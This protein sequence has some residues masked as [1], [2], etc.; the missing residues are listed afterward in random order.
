MTDDSPAFL[1]LTGLTK[2]Y[3]EATA[4]A[5]LDVAVK[6]GELVAFL[7]PSGCGKTTTL[8]MIAGFISLDEG[9]ISIGGKRVDRLPSR[10][11]GTAMVFQD[12]AL[13]PH[14]TVHDNVAF[15]LKMHGVNRAERNRRVEQVLELVQLE[16]VG[17]KY[18]KELSGGMKQRVALAR[19]IVVEP[20]ILLLDEPLSNLDAKLRKQLRTGLRELHD[21]I[22]ITTVFVTHDI[23]EA[24]YLADRVVV[25]SRGHLEQF[26]TPQNIYSNPASVFV[27]DFI[28][29]A[30]MFEGEVAP[31]SGGGSEFR[32]R[33]LTLPMEGAAETTT[34][35]RYTVPPHRIKLSTSRPDSVIA[36]P[37]I[38]AVSAYLGASYSLLVDTDG[39]DPLRFQCDLVA[40]DA[41]AAAL[42]EGTTVWMSWDPKDG[43]HVTE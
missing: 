5:D 30:N 1:K 25:M 14:M 33:G 21:R 17:K 35:G 8:R 4:V 2:R 12:Y 31:T 10:Q 29:H 37:G 42:G 32:G 7:G 15:G 41:D 43:H 3:G 39:S 28:G 40:G 9:E 36:V 24:F 13:F 19:A 20:Q 11:R 34:S 23:E 27:A 38:I 26:D 22:G 6:R 18:P 16:G